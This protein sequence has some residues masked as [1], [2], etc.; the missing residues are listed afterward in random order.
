MYMTCTCFHTHNDVG[1]HIK[2]I[3]AEKPV[4]CMVERG[5]LLVCGQGGMECYGVVYSISTGQTV[6]TLS[7]L[8]GFS[9][10]AMTSSGKGVRHY[11]SRPCRNQGAVLHF[12]MMS[13][14][15]MQN[16]FVVVG[17]WCVQYTC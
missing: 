5:G 13:P 7:G 4:D 1:E 14:G 6:K 10:V 15:E 8:Y 2:E 12:I 16:C 9:N 11:L 3:K 17:L